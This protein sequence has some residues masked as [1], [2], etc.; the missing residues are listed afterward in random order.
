MSRRK[1]PNMAKVS[2]AALLD[3]LSDEQQEPPSLRDL[4]GT[5]DAL[6]ALSGGRNDPEFRPGCQRSRRQQHQASASLSCGGAEAARKRLQYEGL[7]P[8]KPKAAIRTKPPHQA[9]G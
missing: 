9:T 8:F 5:Y 1:P 2:I 4:V 7:L 6:A 3:K